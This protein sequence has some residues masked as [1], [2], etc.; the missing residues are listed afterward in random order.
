MKE[1]SYYNDNKLSVKHHLLNLSHFEKKERYRAKK[2][3]MFY[4]GECEHKSA[5][6]LDRS[7]LGQSWI[8]FDD[9]DYVPSQLID[10]RIKPLIK[11]QAR[12]MFGKAP[13]ILFKPYDKKD[14]DTCEELRQYIDSILNANRFWSNTLKAFRI[15][16]VTKRVLLRLEANPGM[17][18]K[19]FYHSIDDFS[20]NVDPNDVTKLIDVTFVRE[21]P[22][23]EKN[24]DNPEHQFWYKYIYYLKDKKCYLKVQTFKASNLDLVIDEIEQFT[25]LSKIP[26]WVIANEQSIINVIGSSDIKDLKPLQNAYNRRISDFNDALRFQMFGQTTIVDGDE[27]DVNRCRIAPNALMAIKTRSDN[28]TDSTRQAQVKRVESSFSNSEP[29]QTFLKLLDD[30]MHD[31][32][33]IPTDDKTADVPS[34]KTIKY[35]YTELVARCDEK[36]NDWEPVI[37]SLIRL[38]IEACS[39]L[40]C[41]SNW[42]SVWNEL[43]FNIVINKNYPIPEDESDKKTLAMSEVSTGVRSRKNYIK[44]F[45]DDEDYEAQFNEILEEITLIAKAEDSMIDEADTDYEKQDGDDINE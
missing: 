37:R 36:W 42:N 25:G 27:E 15:A 35:I 41:Y 7:L 43:L 21:H 13:D 40:G 4:L 31:K 11:R 32:L 20:Y 22:D 16:T 28:S 44:E 5:S 12:F 8:N 10:N 30:S 33:A 3:F 6:L 34:A 1:L 19:L 29:I 2:D 24:K 14:K 38:I 17:P 39:I 23:N 18:I 26:C 9:L 45:S